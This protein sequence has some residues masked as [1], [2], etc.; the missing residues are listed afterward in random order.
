MVTV[1]L[2]KFCRVY[3]EHYMCNEH[4]MCNNLL[5]PEGRREPSN[6]VGC[7]RFLGAC[8]LY[9]EWYILVD[10]EARE[11]W[12]KGADQDEEEEEVDEEEKDG[13]E[14]GRYRQDRYI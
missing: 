7:S 8:E 5:Q 11:A 3:I 10:T 9:R 4:N 14:V 6:L 2:T 1:L 13:K 12:W